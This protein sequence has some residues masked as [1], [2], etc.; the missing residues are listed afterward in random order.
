MQY[1]LSH[2][3]VDEQ[4]KP[5]TDETGSPAALKTVLSRAVLTDTADNAVTK[6]ERFEVWLKLKASELIVDL[7]NEEA[8]LIKKASSVYP[9]LVYGQIVKWVE[10]HKI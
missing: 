7:T 5:A 1:D 8:A 2:Q 6:L 9:T 3:L 10:G 4:G